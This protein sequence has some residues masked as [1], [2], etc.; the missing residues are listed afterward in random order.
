[1]YGI[2]VE[3]ELFSKALF[4]RGN[5][6]GYFNKD[7]YGSPQQRVDAMTEGL[8]FGLLNTRPNR[9]PSVSDAAEAGYDVVSRM[10]LQ[11]QTR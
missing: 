2:P 10:R 7:D 5:T 6:Q 3:P 8:R 9:R 4:A 1:M 11:S